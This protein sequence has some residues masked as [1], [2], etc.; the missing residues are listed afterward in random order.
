MTETTSPSVWRRHI[1]WERE[2]ERVWWN[3]LQRR[4]SQHIT[5]TITPYIPY[6]YLITSNF[7][8]AF[9]L[10]R[11]G[12]RTLLLNECS[13]STRVTTGSLMLHLHQIS[14]LEPLT[15]PIVGLESESAYELL[16]TFHYSQKKIGTWYN[17]ATVNLIIAS[18]WYN[19][20]I[21]HTQSLWKELTVWCIF[22][23][24]AESTIV[25]SDYAPYVC[26]YL[27]DQ[28]GTLASYTSNIDSVPSNSIRN[29]NH[30]PLVHT[31][32]QEL[33][34]KSWCM[35]TVVVAHE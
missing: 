24:T 7:S 31:S 13:N 8:E 9:Y 11:Q 2:R 12:V 1:W 19:L 23:L 29:N 6:T 3:K 16:S 14:P 21:D 10:G 5:P 34:C 35:V 22:S 26:N 27:I 32:F 18:L 25:S 28:K 30:P 17:L 4:N 20:A 15:S 33:L